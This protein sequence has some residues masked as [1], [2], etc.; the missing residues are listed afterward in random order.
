MNRLLR[1]AAAAPA[2]GLRERLTVAL[3]PRL[4]YAYIRLVRAT[5]RLEY[6]GREVLD[7]TRREHGQFILAFWHSRWVM[8]PYSYSG[9]RL[10]VLTSA[11]RDALMLGR[12]LSRFGLDV[13]L[14]SSSRGGAA[15]LRQLLRAVKEGH[16]VGWAPDGPRGPRRRLKEGLLVAAKLGDLPII[17]VGFSARPARRLR[18]WD[19]TLLPLPFGRGL[20]LYGDPYRVP[21]DSDDDALEQCRSRLEATLNELTDRADEEVGLGVEPPCPSV[22]V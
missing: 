18:S 15:G 1:P 14:G 8:M 3:V 9:G 12:I 21:R 17:P 5:M 7:V 2:V 10:T 4:S 20:F 11:H 6:R 19:R 22:A 13:A 16:D